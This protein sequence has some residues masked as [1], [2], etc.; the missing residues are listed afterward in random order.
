VT[1]ANYLEPDEETRAR[2]WGAQL[3]AV[4]GALTAD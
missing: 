2:D 3:A 1:K 4:V